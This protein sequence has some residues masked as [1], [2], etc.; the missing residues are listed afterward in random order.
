MLNGRLVDDGLNR[1]TLERQKASNV[2]Y[3]SLLLWAC[4]LRHR[5]FRYA[6][7]SPKISPLWGRDSATG[8]RCLLGPS[9]TSAHVVLFGICI[10]KDKPRVEEYTD[11][12]GDGQSRL[13]DLSA[14]PQTHQNVM[15]YAELPHRPFKM[16]RWFHMIMSTV[17]IDVEDSQADISPEIK[18]VNGMVHVYQLT[19][20]G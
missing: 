13:P 3:L 1:R 11:C 18:K 4:V 12:T 16:S 2:Q 7:T 20:F 8:G 5:G 15:F 14:G 9:S 17:R 19:L 6:V 10:F